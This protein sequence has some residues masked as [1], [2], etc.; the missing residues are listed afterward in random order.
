MLVINTSSKLLYGCEGQIKNSIPWADTIIVSTVQTIII[1]MATCGN[2]LVLFAAYRNK[3]W[4]I[5]LGYFLY[6]G[7]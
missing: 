5:L 3:R 2:A 6:S 7:H 1:F 4:A